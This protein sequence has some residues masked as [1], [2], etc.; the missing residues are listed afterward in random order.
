MLAQNPAQSIDEVIAR[1]TDIIDS[2]RKEPGRLGY[3]A[4]LYRRY[5]SHLLKRAVLYRSLSCQPQASDYLFEG[6][7]VNAGLILRHDGDDV[8]HPAVGGDRRVGRVDLD[9]AVDRRWT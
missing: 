2:S 9:D 4:A 3:F 1:L 6:G 8:K 5:V 7:S